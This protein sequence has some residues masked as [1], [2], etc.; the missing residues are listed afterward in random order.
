MTAPL[1][2]RS[3]P[4]SSNCK[5]QAVTVLLKQ[6][7]RSEHEARQA[8]QQQQ[9]QL[10]ETAKVVKTHHLEIE[11]LKEGITSTNNK[12]S[13]VKDSQGKLEQ[14]MCQVEYFVN[15]T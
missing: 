7:A 8:R 11:N 15:K 10:I 13:E 3:K 4:R 1:T 6:S 9:Q 14:R 5:L 12:V 2:N